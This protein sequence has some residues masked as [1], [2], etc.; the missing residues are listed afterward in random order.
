MYVRGETFY[1]LHVAHTYSATKN[2][3]DARDELIDLQP[4]ERE[5]VNIRGKNS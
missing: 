5:C 2:K 4:S 3:L 1:G